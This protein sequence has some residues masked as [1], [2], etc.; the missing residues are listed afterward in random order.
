MMNLCRY[1]RISLGILL[2]LRKETGD[3]RTDG[4]HNHYL[5]LTCKYEYKKHIHLKH[6]SNEISPNKPVFF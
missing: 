3:G 1:H 4:Q 5:I 6:K 2:E